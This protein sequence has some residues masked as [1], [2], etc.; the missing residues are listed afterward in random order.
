MDRKTLTS[1][2]DIGD[3]FHAAYPNG[4]SCVCVVLSVNGN[5]IHAKR[6]TT[7]EDIDFDRETGVEKCPDGEAKAVMNSIEQ[8][9]P[10]IR[11]TLFGLYRKYSGITQKDWKEE[12]LE[13]FKLTASEKKALLFVDSHYASNPLPP[14]A[15]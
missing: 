11:D 5:V 3:T 6:M 2:L 10:D 4:A 9:P 1:D 12:D 14:L 13:R 7:Q 15:S 8:L